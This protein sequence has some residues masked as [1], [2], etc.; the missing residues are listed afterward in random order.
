MTFLQIKKRIFEI[1]LAATF[2]LQAVLLKLVAPLQIDPHHDGIIL[3]AAVASSSGYMG[4]SEAFSQYGPLSP[5]IHGL[6]LNIFGNSMLNLRYFAALNA[7]LIS[8][9]LYILL[10]KI[11]NRWTAL[12]ISSSWIYTSAIWSTTFPGALLPWPSLIATALL[13][14][15]VNLLLPI[16]SRHNFSRGQ[17]YGRLAF[18]GSFFGLTGFAR[19][20]TWLAAAITVSLLIL[21][22][23]RI[24]TEVVIFLVG[25]TVSISLMFAW[26][27]GIGGWVSY[28]NQV[29]IWPLSAYSTLGVNNNYNRYQ[30]ASYIVQS[31][32]FIVLIYLISK[33]RSILKSVSLVL[34]IVLMSFSLVLFNGFYISKQTS[35]NTTL[36]VILGEPQEKI[37]ISLGYYACATACLIPIYILASSKFRVTR[38][39]FEMFFIA[40]IGLVGVVQLYP[41]PDVLHLWWVAPIFL[42]CSILSF[43]LI[44]NKFKHLNIETL[45][46]AVAAF[47]ALGIILATPYIAR[48]WSAYSLPVL[49]GTYTF[50]AKANAMNQFVDMQQYILPRKTSFDCPDGIFAV[51]NKEYQAIDEWFVNW[52]MLES[53][54]PIIGEVR[55]ICYRDLEY[56]QKESQRLGMEIKA[57]RTTSYAN[58]S[59]A[60]L[61]DKNYS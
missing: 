17:T 23:R 9:L 47:S 11:A 43:Q 44:V 16:F 53:D 52:G 45:N 2:L 8:F 3:G 7:L 24:T 37:I 28:L 54:S 57:Y 10:K 40:C 20:Q 15:G 61:V 34:I 60:V 26:L 48:P 51:S 1:S 13:L 6:F 41:Q 22:F 56:V 35:W 46:I 49:K 12:I 14:S 55:V 21:Y 38:E 32:V 18:A 36:R 33:L 5:L 19:Q 4:P 30:F 50:E 39:R 58:I 59:F 29:I 42:P 27:V 31:I 25:V